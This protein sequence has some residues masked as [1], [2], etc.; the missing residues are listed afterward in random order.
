MV[1]FELLTVILTVMVCDFTVAPVSAS[2][3]LPT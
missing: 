2:V 3:I 1:G